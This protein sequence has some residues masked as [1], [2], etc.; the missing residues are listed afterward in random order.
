MGKEQDKG[1]VKSDSGFVSIDYES[2]GVINRKD[3][4]FGYR[5]WGGIERR[6]LLS[7]LSAHKRV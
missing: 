4:D 3:V 2:S 7:G 1:T 6:K 5:K